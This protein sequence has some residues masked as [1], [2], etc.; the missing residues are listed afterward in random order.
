MRGNPDGYL[1]GALTICLENPEIPGR[2]SNGTVHPGGNFPKKSD[3]FR[4]ITFFPF[5]PKRPKLP[6]F[7]SREGETFTGILYAVAIW[8]VTSQGFKILNGR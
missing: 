5:L 4:G 6:G 7:M 1:Q 2:I 8:P 3:T